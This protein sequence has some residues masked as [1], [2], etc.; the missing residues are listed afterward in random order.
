MEVFPAVTQLSKLLGYTYDF[1]HSQTK[2]VGPNHFP[3]VRLVALLV[4]VTK[5][6]YPFDDIK[7]YPAS[8]EDPSAQL[9]D[10]N[11][12]VILQRNFDNRGKQGGKL[13]R[14]NEFKV[15]ESDVFQMAPE[16]LDEYMDWYEK[17]WVDSKGT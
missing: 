4:V 1:P 6:F 2:R 17:F 16:Q 7:R 3:E 5:L 8:L 9:I 11:K 10:W 12:W 13:G 15:K 14:G